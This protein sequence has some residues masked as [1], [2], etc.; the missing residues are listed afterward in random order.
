MTEREL[1]VLRL[2]SK[3]Y[4]TTEIADTL[5]LA[6]STVKTYRKSLLRKLKVKNVVGLVMYAMKHKII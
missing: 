5:N 6:I 2:I 1:K 4:N 3:E